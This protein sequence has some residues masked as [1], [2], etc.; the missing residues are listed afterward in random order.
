MVG[1]RPSEWFNATFVNYL[2]RDSRGHYLRDSQGEIKTA[3]A[4]VVEN[5]KTTHG[6]ANGESQEILL[7]NISN[8]ELA[9]LMHMR[10]LAHGYK[11]KQPENSTNSDITN[12]FFKPIQQTMNLA[13]QKMGYP[14][15]SLPTTY[16]TRHQAMANAKQSG[17][18]DREIAAMFGH[19]SLFTAKR[20]YGKKINVWMKMVFRASPESMM[21]VPEIA[22]SHNN[23]LP[24]QKIMDVA[25]SWNESLESRTSLPKEGPR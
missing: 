1:L 22:S 9:T 13:L 14:K 21:A 2:Y 20:H 8:S 11:S 3:I 23:A 17:L 24:T 4:I 6:R 15:K 18:T 19:S 5:A 10:E 12:G 25:T 16:S 7:H